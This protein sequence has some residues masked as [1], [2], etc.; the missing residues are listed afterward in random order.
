MKT[1]LRPYQREGLSYRTPIGDALLTVPVAEALGADIECYGFIKEIL[2]LAG[3]SVHDEDIMYDTIFDLNP[4]AA[5]DQTVFSHPISKTVWGTPEFY[6]KYGKM[7][8]TEIWATILGTAPVGQ[9]R[10]KDYDPIPE[11]QDKVLLVLGARQVKRMWKQWGLFTEYLYHKKIPYAFLPD[12]HSARELVNILGSAKHMVTTFTGP[13]HIRAALDKPQICLCVGDDPYLFAPLSDKAKVLWN[14][15]SRC[16]YDPPRLQGL[17]SADGE[18]VLTNTVNMCTD[19]TCQYLLEQTI[20]EV[21]GELDRDL[22][23]KLCTSCKI[24][25]NGSV[26]CRTPTGSSAVNE[27]WAG[28]VTITVSGNTVVFTSLDGNRS[29]AIPLK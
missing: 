14:G 6:S 3:V 10:I 1:L 13:M 17:R 23:N 8:I 18:R 26:I 20:L 7:H 29:V 27:L 19:P 9:L 25:I 5:I 21:T 4:L 15:C 2:Q 24:S 12:T 11:Y 16:F 22:L 28:T